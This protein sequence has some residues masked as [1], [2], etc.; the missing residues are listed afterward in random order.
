MEHIIGRV[1][2]MWYRSLS[3]G[4]AMRLA[5]RRI[6]GFECKYDEIDKPEENTAENNDRERHN[7][8]LLWMEPKYKENR[9]TILPEP[10]S[11]RTWAARVRNGNC[12]HSVLYDKPESPMI[13]PCA[14]V[15]L[16][17][18]GRLQVI[19][20]FANI[21]LTPVKTSYSGGTWHVEGQLNEHICASA[22]YYYDC[23]NIT[24]SRVAFHGIMEEPDAYNSANEMETYEQDEH[25][26]PE[27][28]CGFGNGIHVF[29]PLAM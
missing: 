29:C 26:A 1:L 5:K 13:S 17:R 2:P 15:H 23:H 6:D 27:E 14:F 12:I 16:E 24:E 11:Y 28:I 20:K 8:Q 22:I 10:G 7:D 19:V 4:R 25:K 18:Q 3:M 21:H 9:R